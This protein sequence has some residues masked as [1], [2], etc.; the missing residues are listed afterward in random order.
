[1]KAIITTRKLWWILRPVIWSIA[2][3]TTSNNTYGPYGAEERYRGDD[4]DDKQEN[5]SVLP[6]KILAYI[7]GWTGD[8]LDALTFYFYE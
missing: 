7:C 6:Q 5:V 8:N 2:F 4:K 3:H 1:M